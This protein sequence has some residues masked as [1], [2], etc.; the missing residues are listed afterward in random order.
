LRAGTQAENAQDALERGRH[1]QRNKTHCKH[2]HP[3]S[4]GNLLM[5]K[6]QRACRTCRRAALA[7]YRAKGGESNV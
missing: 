6:T 7:R 4:G 2:G 1:A 3:L 5:L